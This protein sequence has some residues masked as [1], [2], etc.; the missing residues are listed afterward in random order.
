MSDV[1][2]QNTT[3]RYREVTAV[4]DISLVIE[5]GELLV[6]L[7]P[8]G[9]GKTT[10]LRMIA[11]LVHPTEGRILIDG[12]DVTN[13]T[14][15]HRDIAMV[16]QDLAL[17]PHMTVRENMSF[18]LKM[19]EMKADIIKQ[20]VSETAEMLEIGELLDRYP[21]ELSGGQQQRVALGRSLVREPKVFL[22]DEPLSSLD[23][24][25]RTMMR[26]EIQSIHQELQETMV[27]VTHDQEIAMTL[28]DRI[29]V[30]N[31]GELQQVDDPLMIYQRP[32]NE[33]VARFIGSPDMNFFDATVA[34]NGDTIILSTESFEL[35]L[36]DDI[37]SGRWREFD[38]KNVRVGIR[39]EDVYNPANIT[40]NYHNGE[41]V[42]GTV[43]IIEE[44]G[45]VID[46]HIDVG[47]LDFIAQVDIN[48]N[49]NVNDTVRVVLDTTQL[50]IF[51]PTTGKRIEELDGE[52]GSDVKPS[53]DMVLLEET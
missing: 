50:H 51:D 10:T 12:E 16:F 27:Y 28:G 5:D 33:F 29:A 14:P 38:G 34:V 42:T 43:E 46:L 44:L 9:C 36:G 15:G 35:T 32:T 47:G 4:N 37:P 53:E 23:A 20:R 25:L 45:S 22:M 49:V 39:P 31:E 21:S 6:L 11:G 52:L 17:Y 2:F 7:G 18:P 48:T 40:R 3:K 30:M 26:A 8:S 24:K 13:V 1:E 19:E 41:T